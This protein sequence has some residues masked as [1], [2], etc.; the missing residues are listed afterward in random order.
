[1]SSLM[2]YAFTFEI[3]LLAVILLI[4]LTKGGENDE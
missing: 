3:V 4:L 1:M 2:L